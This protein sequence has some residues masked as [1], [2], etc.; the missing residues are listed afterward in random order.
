MVMVFAA[1]CVVVL[2]LLLVM[3]A[4]MVT[5]G[6]TTHGVT[7]VTAVQVVVVAVDRVARIVNDE[8]VGG[9]F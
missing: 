6:A 2:L 9:R 3:R 7:V 5:A 8:A 1:R 4:E